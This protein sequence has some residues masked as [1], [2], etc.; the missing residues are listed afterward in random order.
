MTNKAKTVFDIFEQELRIYGESEVAELDRKTRKTR[1]IGKVMAKMSFGALVG[2]ASCRLD[3]D[4]FQRT[5]SQAL[6]TLRRSV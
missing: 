1:K 5:L 6:E 4:P 2:V 3:S